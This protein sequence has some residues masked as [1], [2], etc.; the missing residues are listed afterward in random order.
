[1]RTVW[2]RIVDLESQVRLIIR[3]LALEE[4]A[5][6]T[7]HGAMSARGE[8][9]MLSVKVGDKGIKF[10][11]TEFDGPNGTGGIIKPT[12]KI[13]FASDSPAATVDNTTQ[14]QNADGSVTVDIQAVSAGVAHITGVDTADPNAIAA[15]DVLTVTDVPPPP[16]PPKGAVSATGVLSVAP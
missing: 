9:N 7:K 4:Q 15:G 16:P 3:Y 11:F 1:M 14:V 6:E 8:L 2:H 5:K 13:L 12:G 10:T